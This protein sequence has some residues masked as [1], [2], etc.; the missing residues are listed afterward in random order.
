MAGGFPVPL[1]P[2]QRTADPVI[3]IRQEEIDA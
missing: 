2:G 3:V 1:L